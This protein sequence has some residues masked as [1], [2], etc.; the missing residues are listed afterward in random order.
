MKAGWLYLTVDDLAN[1]TPVE[2]NQL[3][4]ELN[5]KSGEIKGEEK[6][7]SKEEFDK[8]IEELIKLGRLDKKFLKEK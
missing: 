5:K 1:M 7:P 6:K 3:I 4:I 8:K 2:I